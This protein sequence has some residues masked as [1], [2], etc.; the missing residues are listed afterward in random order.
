MNPQE[1][2]L[3]G[4]FVAYG[5]ENGLI[6]PTKMGN[7]KNSI[8]A[9]T[10]SARSGGYMQPGGESREEI[11]K[12]FTGTPEFKRGLDLMMQRENTDNGDPFY[13]AMGE[14]NYSA[15]D[16]AKYRKAIGSMNDPEWLERVPQKSHYIKDG[17]HRELQD[18]MNK[19]YGSE[20]YNT[21]YA[22]GSGGP[23]REDGRYIPTPERRPTPFEDGRVDP[24][25]LEAI[26]PSKP[27]ENDPFAT[28]TFKS[29]KL[30]GYAE[31]GI[32]DMNEDELREFIAN[33]GEVEY[34][35]S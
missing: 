11:L 16:Q 9:G 18:L 17:R 8:F 10:N 19:A 3:K 35:E 33:G 2:K 7:E 29:Y 32:F 5:Q 4:K 26:Q 23:R 15:E 24:R 20:R 27:D 28:E 12:Q 14:A 25:T 31:G 6:D 30:G 21:P 1:A 34:L 22:V 13:D